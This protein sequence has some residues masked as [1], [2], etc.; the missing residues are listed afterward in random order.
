MTDTPR[1]INALVIDAAD[2]E[3]LAAF[4]SELLDRPVVDRTGDHR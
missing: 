2:P 4:W 1:Q 3:L